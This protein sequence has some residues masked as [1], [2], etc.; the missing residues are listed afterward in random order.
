MVEEEK[1]STRG[2]VGQRR[3]GAL[4][5]MKVSDGRGASGC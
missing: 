4:V 5:E 2:A 3:Q 1:G